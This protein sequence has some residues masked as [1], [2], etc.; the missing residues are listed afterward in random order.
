MTV[1]FDP[2]QRYGF[3]MFALFRSLRYLA[4]IFGI[5]ALIMIMSGIS[6]ANAYPDAYPKFTFLDTLSIANKA[7]SMP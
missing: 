6:E 1:E 7:F 4:F 3:G 5:F 2:M